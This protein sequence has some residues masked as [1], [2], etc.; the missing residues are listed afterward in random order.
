MNFKD[1][2]LTLDLSDKKQKEMAV[3]MVFSQT[4]KDNKVYN[5]ALKLV[6]R[7]KGFGIKRKS[8][9]IFDIVQLVKNSN[10]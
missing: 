4:N 6:P 1:G 9:M 5:D 2:K 10:E 3:F 8:K 7:I